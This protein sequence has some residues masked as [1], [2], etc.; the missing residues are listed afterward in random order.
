MVDSE[1]LVPP[2]LRTTAS[3]FS[4]KK[5]HK[6]FPC[7]LLYARFAEEYPERPPEIRFV[8]PIRHCNTNAHGRIGHSIFDRNYTTD[9]PMSTILA[10]V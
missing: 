5:H 1:L 4:S 9:T 7:W 6:V 2:G 8:T 10:S 3:P